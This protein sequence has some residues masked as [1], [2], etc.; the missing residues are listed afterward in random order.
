MSVRPVQ[1]ALALALVAVAT[2]ACRG[3]TAVDTTQVGV[4]PGTVY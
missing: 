4:A 1:P 3:G 2:S